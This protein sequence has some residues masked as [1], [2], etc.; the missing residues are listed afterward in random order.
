MLVPVA[1]K[2]QLF[3]FSQRKSKFLRTPHELQISHV[4]VAEKPV[5]AFTANRLPQ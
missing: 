1:D 2:N 3:D 4:R 5:S